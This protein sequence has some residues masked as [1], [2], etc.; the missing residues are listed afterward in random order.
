MMVN[1]HTTFGSRIF[2]YIPLIAP[3]LGHYY[4]SYHTAINDKVCNFLIIIV[5]Q[6]VACF[7]LPEMFKV[8]NCET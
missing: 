8:S 2:I 7:Q 3:L 5:L 6:V 4:T 1:I